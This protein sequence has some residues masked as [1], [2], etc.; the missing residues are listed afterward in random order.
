MYYIKII[1]RLVWIRII[2]FNR[3]NVLDKV[4]NLI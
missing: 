3:T 1:T 4:N 2:L